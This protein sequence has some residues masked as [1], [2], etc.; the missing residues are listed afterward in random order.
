MGRVT[1]L[2]VLDKDLKK[3][4]KAFEVDEEAVAKEGAAKKRG[5]KGKRDRGEAEDDG[6]KDDE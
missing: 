3:D 2:L 1:E 4:R 5:R 6:M